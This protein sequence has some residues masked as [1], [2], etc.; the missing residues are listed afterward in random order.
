MKCD[1]VVFYLLFNELFINDMDSAYE[2]ITCRINL[3]IV[4]GNVW[5]SNKMFL[6]IESIY[7]K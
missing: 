4:Y 3:L 6:I 5:K 1:K 2:N 7:W